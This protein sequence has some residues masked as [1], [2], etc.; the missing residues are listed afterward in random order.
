MARRGVK[1]TQEEEAKVRASFLLT[2]SMTKTAQDLGVSKATVHAIV[3][4]QE[5]QKEELPELKT[6]A[7]LEA[8]RLSWVSVGATVVE[9]EAVH[10]RIQLELGKDIPDPLV[11][12]QWVGTL[13][14][15]DIAYGIDVDK[16][17][18]LNEQA[19][20][21][22]A[23]AAQLRGSMPAGM[24]VEVMVSAVR[25]LIGSTQIN[26]ALLPPAAEPDGSR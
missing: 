3:H 5:K 10:K 23:G 7:E 25:F 16:A 26:P 20:Q 14:D 17:R 11:V 4:R 6:V 22:T 2:K 12:R 1:L 24:T 15:L 9:K 18:L 13:K 8:R 21:I 19:T